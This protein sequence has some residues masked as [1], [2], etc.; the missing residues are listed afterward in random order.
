[1]R[2]T[3]EVLDGIPEPGPI[4]NPKQA[5]T[6]GDKRNEGNLR[7]FPIFFACFSFFLR[8]FFFNEGIH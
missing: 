2:I 1:M 7:Y 5:Q 4:K 6:R 3:L 8:F